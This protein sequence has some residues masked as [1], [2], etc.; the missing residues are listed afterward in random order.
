MQDVEI[1]QTRGPTLRFRG[2]MLAEQGWTAPNHG[3]RIEL[4]QTEGGALVAVTEGEYTIDEIDRRALVVEPVEDEQAMRFAVM[5]FF[6]WEN[7]ARSMV[8]KQ[9][10]WRLVREVP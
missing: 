6:D 5:D 4:W 7:R 1:K 3:M 9:L 2:S 10:K 8:R